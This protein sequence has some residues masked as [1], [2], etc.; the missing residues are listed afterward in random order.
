MSKK[1]TGGVDFNGLSRH[2]YRGGP[3]AMAIHPQEPNW[4]WSI[5]RD[6]DD[7]EDALE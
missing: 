7:K 3:S 4:S 5:G 1:K 2:G 6:C